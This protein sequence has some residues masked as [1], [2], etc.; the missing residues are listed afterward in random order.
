M[1]F[2]FLFFQ[3]VSCLKYGFKAV[4]YIKLF[5]QSL[6]VKIESPRLD[7]VLTSPYFF[8]Y[9]F[10]EKCDIFIAHQKLKQLKSKL[11]SQA[12]RR[13]SWEDM[14]VLC[15]MGNEEEDESCLLYTSDAADE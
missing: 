14:M 7:R 9:F 4:S 15:E 6:Y 12:K 2:S 11:E 3:P 10:S 13:S 1:V 5:A 8:I